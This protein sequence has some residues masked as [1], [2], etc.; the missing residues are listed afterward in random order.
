MPPTQRRPQA[1]AA[2]AKRNTKNANAELSRVW[3][4]EEVERAQ[5][6]EQV[7]HSEI[8]SAMT[9]RQMLENSPTQSQGS[10]PHI[11]FLA[12]L[13]PAQQILELVLTS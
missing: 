12:V 3:K 4:A 11:N 8:Y 1:V 2:T 13:F 9:H 10:L 7:K 5:Q 6:S